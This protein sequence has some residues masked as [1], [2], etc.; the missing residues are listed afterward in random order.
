MIAGGSVDLMGGRLD[1]LPVFADKLAEAGAVIEEITGG[2]RVTKG[3]G[4]VRPVDVTTG[5]FPEFPTDLQAQ[6]MAMM[7]LADGTSAQVE[8]V[9]ENRFMHVPELIR[10]GAQIDVQGNTAHVTGVKQMR[11]AQ[12]MATDLRASVS[13]LLSGLAAEGETQ[14]NRVY[15]LDRGYEH[16]EEKLGGVGADIERVH[17][18]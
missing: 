3:D 5:P 9:F 10:M 4:P 13:L 7:C 12:V 17:G 2:L 16:V 11:G 14:V 18:S 1:L 8:T 6:F 15:H